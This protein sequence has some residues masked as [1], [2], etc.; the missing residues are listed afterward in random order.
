MDSI[1]LPTQI[2]QKIE[3][4]NIL[5][6]GG[7]GM[8]GRGVVDILV[9]F[10]ANVTSVSLDDLKLNQSVNYVKGDLSNLEFCLDLTSKMDYVFHIAGIKGSVV[11]T[12]ERPASFF[13][14]LLMM[15]TNILEASRI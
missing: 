10:G 6:T 11:V 13:V 5:V 8:I 9:N 15:N 3:N 14:P 1:S 2:C 7:T 12:K 4:S